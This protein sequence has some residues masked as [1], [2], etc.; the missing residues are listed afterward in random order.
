LDNDY[1]DY[2]KISNSEFSISE[3]LILKRMEEE[4]ILMLFQLSVLLD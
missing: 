1:A 2:I 4:T 3:E